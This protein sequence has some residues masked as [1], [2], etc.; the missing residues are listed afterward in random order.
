V[1]RD[2]KAEEPFHPSNPGTGRRNRGRASG[3]ESGSI[4]PLGDPVPQAK[5][6]AVKAGAALQR[7]NAQSLIGFD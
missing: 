6:G 7:G 4:N 3:D 1:P 2:C 5:P